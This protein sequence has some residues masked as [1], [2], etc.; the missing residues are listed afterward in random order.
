MLKFVSKKISGTFVGAVA[1][2]SMVATLFAGAAPASA[3]SNSNSNYTSSSFT[4]PYTLGSTYTA[5]G[6]T[7]KSLDFRASIASEDITSWQGQAITFSKVVTNGLAQ[8]VGSEY[9][10]GYIRFYSDANSQ[11]SIGS[12]NYIYP[13]GSNNTPT[14]ITVPANARTARMTFYTNFS[15]FNDQSISSGNFA[16]NFNISVAGVSQGKVVLG[17]NEA[18]PATGLYVS[19]AQVTVNGITTGYTIPQGASSESTTVYACVNASDISSSTTLS[20]NLTNG[21]TAVQGSYV[22]NNV[23]TFGNW[24]SQK[25]GQTAD[26]SNQ[27]FSPLLNNGQIIV[28]ADKW[29]S[30]PSAGARSWDLSITNQNNVEVSAPCLAPTPTDTPTL[31]YTNSQLTLTS[32]PSVSNGQQWNYK[33]YAASDSSASN[34]LY[35]NSSY[36]SGT[37]TVYSNSL[38]ASTPLVA[39]Y[40]GKLSLGYTTI[41]STP[42]PASNSVSLPAAAIT[43]TSQISNGDNP[44][45]AKLLTPT[46]QYVDYSAATNSGGMMG[47]SNPV[48]D[49]KDGFYLLRLGNMGETKLFR[50]NSSG[51]DSSFAGNASS[52]TLA[53]DIDPSSN[54]PYPATT[55]VGWY[56]TRDKWVAVTIMDSSDANGNPNDIAGRHLGL[57]IKTGTQGSGTVS[58]TNLTYTQVDAFCNSQKAGTKFANAGSLEVVSS[59]LAKPLIKLPC[60]ASFDSMSYVYSDVTVLASITLGNAPALTSVYKFN[61]LEGDNKYGGFPRYA[62]YMSA[63]STSQPGSVSAY[64]EAS[65]ATD[66]GLAFFA[67]SYSLSSATPPAATVDSIKLVRVKMNGTVTVTE[68]SV[69][70]VTINGMTSLMSLGSAVPSALP[71]LPALSKGTALLGIR[72]TV[73][74]T[75]PNFVTTYKLQSLNAGTGVFSA[76]DPINIDSD[77]NFVGTSSLAFVGGGQLVGDTGSVLLQRFVMSGSGSMYTYTRGQA[78]LDIASKNLDTGEAVTYTQP[79]VAGIYS[80]FYV[81][82]Q[83]RMNWLSTMDTKKFGWV[84]WNS[85]ASGG[86][87]PAGTSVSNQTSLFVVSSAGGTVTINGTGLGTVTAVTV[88]GVRA[89]SFTK[90]ATKLAVN[91]P[92][93]L[94][95]AQT[96]TVTIGGNNYDLAS[97]TYLASKQAQTIEDVADS[98]SNTWDGVSNKKTATFPATTSV[99]LPTTIKVDKPAV[100]SVSGQVVTMNAAGTCVVTVASAGD[101]GTNAASQTTSIVVA[102]RTHQI[103]DIITLIE[104]AGTTW[105]GSN[106]TVTIPS[107]LT[108]V[109]LAA[110]V[111]VA[112]ASVCT[113]SAA[114]ITLKAAGTCAVSV[115][116]AA[117]AGTD[118]IAKTVR[119]IIVAKGN[120]HLEVPA[121]FTVTN[122]PADENNT[123]PVDA[124]IANGAVDD[125]ELTYASSNEDICTVDENGNVTGVAVGTCVI[126]TDAEAGPNWL[127]DEATTTVTVE[128]SAT[129]IPDTLPEVGDGNLSPKPV[130]NN[131]SAFVATNDPS[132]LVKWDKAAGLLTLQS[133]GVY[134]G[135]IKAELTFTKNGT[136]FTC[137]NVFGTTTAM[138]SKTAAQRK[139]ALK[140]KVYTAGAAACKDA[141]GLSVPG[142]IDLASDFAKIKKVAKVAG[143]ATTVGTTKYEAAAQAALKGFAGNVT[144]KIT[145]Y[146]AWPTTM[147]NLAGA[148][149]IPA[150]IR[151]TVISLQ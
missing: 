97:I 7:S 83:G 74:G 147:K 85:T 125:A 81:D 3:L 48:S 91:L 65:A 24:Q 113:L 89:L 93:N 25:S 61:T 90:A 38:P 17:A 96:I 51:I 27:T 34:P 140:T 70:T 135:F 105:T 53:S 19:S 99:G 139:A 108:S 18:P 49:G 121:S 148:K 60:T 129:Q 75:S 116:G 133:K 62:Q 43:L 35:S 52:I 42:G 36:M 23:S 56:G 136:T 40:V 101:L 150:T 1:A 50:L 80:L 66:T 145:R 137:T 13:T 144:I 46:G 12:D 110:T 63:G 104:G 94:S 138:P 67:A 55:S 123:L 109:G 68:N 88:G 37:Q 44:G 4:V 79:M 119:N 84:R 127:A 130:V 71:V 14:S 45:E 69:P 2:L 103:N 76:G 86:D 15:T 112:P 122:N 72:R 149:K 131:K 120:L 16:T 107:L 102:K 143:N 146:R 33:I 118:A 47:S 100:C 106:Q 111:T 9:T 11:T 32:P 151:T 28:T 22:W 95:G 20:A 142:S 134:T 78:T 26:F 77:S 54:D 58:T 8:N 92:K 117:D 29:N 126:T 132:L 57:Q 64:P 6:M 124:G 128:D 31:A 98:T 5:S 39:R 30:T 10:S 82:A 21:G 59:P 115:T 41:Y 87:L 73:T 141:S 114:I